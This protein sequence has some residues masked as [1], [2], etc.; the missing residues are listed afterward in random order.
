MAAHEQAGPGRAGSAPPV[1]SLPTA[2]DAAIS[3][4]YAAH[5][6]RLVRLAWLLLRDQLAAEDVV[7]DAF[8]ATHRNW[9]SIRETVGREVWVPSAASDWLSP[10]AWRISERADPSAGRLRTLNHGCVIID[11]TPLNA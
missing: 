11:S 4:L 10:A 9:R 5:W 7:Q 2:P 6:Q 8:V 3:E 1:T